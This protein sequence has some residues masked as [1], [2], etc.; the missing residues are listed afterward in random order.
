[1]K[2]K[3]A[4]VLPPTAESHGGISDY[5]ETQ[6][7]TV[8]RVRGELFSDPFKPK[9]TFTCKTITFNTASVNLF[10]DTQY[11]TISIDESN[12]RLIVDPATYYAR[13]HLKF[14]NVKNGKNVPRTCTTK[15]F[16]Q[17]LFERMKWNPNAKY[18]NMAMVHELDGKKSMV[19]NLDNALGVFSKRLP[20]GDD[21]KKSDISSA[22]PLE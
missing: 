15:H 13:N 12:L 11:V 10:P 18:H 5:S 19:F 3:N 14:A 1:M 17:M 7:K 9:V 16:C 20:V 4:S 8:Q 22:M 21:E 6:E 2:N